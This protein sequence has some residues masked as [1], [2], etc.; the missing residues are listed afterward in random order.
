MSST[1]AEGRGGFGGTRIAGPAGRPSHSPGFLPP[2]VS[3]NSSPGLATT[4]A[5]AP[6]R[7]HEGA[8]NLSPRRTEPGS[9]A[10]KE[11]SEG[12][13][14]PAGGEDSR[15]TTRPSPYPRFSYG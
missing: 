15:S 4:P 2:S 8:R 12:T 1:R 13:G 11:K 5:P 7:S 6:A 10:T 14:L 3:G 9:S